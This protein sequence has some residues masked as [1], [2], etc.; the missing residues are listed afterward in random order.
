MEN[1]SANK[2]DTNTSPPC[3][4]VI[5]GAAGDLTK[6]KLVPALYNL[7]ESRLL[8]ENF[9]VIGVARAWMEYEEFR[10]RLRDDMREFATDEVKPELWQWLEER[11]YYLRGDF[12]DEDT[13]ARLQKL[14]SKIDKE[15]STQ[16]NYFIYL[17][18]A[19]DYFACDVDNLGAFALTQ[20]DNNACHSDAIQRRC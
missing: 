16:D 4:M 5:F 3:I 1:N 14:L 19:P 6:R 18:M 2:S 15:R 10:R 8:T 20:A 7:R 12:N 9:A 13:F 17:V 11:L